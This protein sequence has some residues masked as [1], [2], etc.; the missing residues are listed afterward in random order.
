MNLSVHKN[1][2]DQFLWDINSF[3]CVFLGHFFLSFF[4][5]IF[6]IFW[7]Q[8]MNSTSMYTFTPHTHRQMGVHDQQSSRGPASTHHIQI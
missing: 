6:W 2:S 5:L 7:Q 4:F 3:M 8:Y 1:V